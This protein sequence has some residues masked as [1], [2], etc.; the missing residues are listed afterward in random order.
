MINRTY[1]LIL[2]WL[3]TILVTGAEWEYYCVC[4]RGTNILTISSPTSQTHISAKVGECLPWMRAWDS[5]HSLVG[6]SSLQLYL[7]PSNTSDVEMCKFR[8]GFAIY[9]E[10]GPFWLKYDSSTAF[11]VG[12]TKATWTT[13]RNLCSTYNGSL[14]MTDSEAKKRELGQSLTSLG[15][16][17]DG[18]TNNTRYF[19]TAGHQPGIGVAF[20]LRSADNSFLDENWKFNYV[21][22]LT[23]LPAAKPYLG[24]GAVTS[25]IS[26]NNS[27][28]GTDAILQRINLTRLYSSSDA[29][30]QRTNLTRLYFSSSA[31]SVSTTDKLKNIFSVSI[32][33]FVVFI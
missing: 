2:I 15:Y 32:I 22:I 28:T 19:W 33:F 29:I 7:F 4:N 26:V 14:Y 13:A 30:L 21:C 23:Q 20:D 8:S 12:T 5:H 25:I 18:S 16:K 10:G 1:V 17:Y 31:V 3:N 24:G 27:T 11:L 6:S 9:G